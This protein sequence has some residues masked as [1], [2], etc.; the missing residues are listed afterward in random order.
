MKRK[1]LRPIG[2]QEGEQIVAKLRSLGPARCDHDLKLLAEEH[3]TSQA[4]IRRV[5]KAEGLRI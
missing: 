4:E 3:S 5:C 2:W 1:R